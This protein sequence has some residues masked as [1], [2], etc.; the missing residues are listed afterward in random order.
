MG[1]W[2]IHLEDVLLNTVDI[3]LA[4]NLPVYIL[5]VAVESYPLLLIQHTQH[6]RNHNGFIAPVTCEEDSK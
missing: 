6:F 2:G 4:S 1:D 3:Q 5:G